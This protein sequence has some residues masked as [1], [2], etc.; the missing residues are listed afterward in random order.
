M[1]KKTTDSIKKTKGSLRYQRDKEREP[2]KGIFRFHEVPGGTMG[3][4]YKAWKEDPVE[5]FNLVDGQVYTIPLGV[6]RHLNKNGKY[7]VHV[8]KVEEGGK[9][10][11]LIGKMVSRFSFQSLEFMDIGDM[12]ATGPSGIEQVVYSPQ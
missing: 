9:P 1:V 5:R 11:M 4:I 3:F 7:P 6:A 2:V 12:E 10:S 8:H